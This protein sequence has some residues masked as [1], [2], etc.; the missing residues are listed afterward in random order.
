M[1]VIISQTIAYMKKP[2]EA[3]ATGGTNELGDLAVSEAS[4]LLLIGVMKSP[5]APSPARLPDPFGSLV[6]HARE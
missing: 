6:M 2:P 5:L 3:S 4:L 1:P